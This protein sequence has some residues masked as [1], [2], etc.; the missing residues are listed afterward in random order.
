VPSHSTMEHTTWEIKTA[1]SMYII[2][3]VPMVLQRINYGVTSYTI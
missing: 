3:I 2:K 1:V